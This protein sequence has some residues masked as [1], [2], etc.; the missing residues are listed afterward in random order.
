MQED[1]TPEGRNPKS[2]SSLKMAGRQSEEV[3]AER[4]RKP[5]S[6]AVVSWMGSADRE[7]VG[8]FGTRLVAWLARTWTPLLCALKGQES[9]RELPKIL[10]SL[11]GCSGQT[12]KE[13]RTS[14]ED[15]SRSRVLGTQIVSE[16]PAG[17][18]AFASTKAVPGASNPIVLLQCYPTILWRGR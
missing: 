16:I 1:Q 9:S 8:V 15:S 11:A 7:P 12:M 3:A 13:V 5:V 10:R 14:R 18:V 17:S 6:G 4:L 2:D